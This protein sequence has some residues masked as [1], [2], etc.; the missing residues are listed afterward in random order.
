MDENGERFYLSFYFMQN[1]LVSSFFV[2]NN[3]CSFSLSQR[4]WTLVQSRH[5]LV[6]VM[7]KKVV[8]EHI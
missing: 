2:N 3:A 5:R 8:D 7:E 4:F 6:L 1:I